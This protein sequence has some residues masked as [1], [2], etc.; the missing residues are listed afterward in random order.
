METPDTESR[1]LS[2]ESTTTPAFAALRWASCDTEPIVVTKEPYAPSI[3]VEPRSEAI[4]SAC[5][6]LPG[7]L[8]ALEAATRLGSATRF[9]LTAIVAASTLPAAKNGSVVW[10]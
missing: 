8:A 6:P 7:W 5:S 9:G 4:A 2:S 1:R 10:V 3:D